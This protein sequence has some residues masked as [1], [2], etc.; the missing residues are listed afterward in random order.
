VVFRLTLQ[1]FFPILPPTRS[2]FMLPIQL[3]AEFPYEYQVSRISGRSFPLTSCHRFCHGTC[4]FCIFQ[5]PAWGR[6]AEHQ[7][8]CWHFFYL[9]GHGFNRSRNIHKNE[10]GGS[11][12]LEYLHACLLVSSPFPLPLFSSNFAMMCPPL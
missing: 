8:L 11:A 1:C 3:H 7:T 5:L 10:K 9:A 12:W 4:I 6:A 2:Q